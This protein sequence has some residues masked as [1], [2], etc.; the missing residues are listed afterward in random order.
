MRTSA[1]GNQYMGGRFV[2][3]TS[4]TLWLSAITWLSK[5]ARTR[6]GLYSMCTPSLS[7]ALSEAAGTR[8]SI[9]CFSFMAI[10]LIRHA[11]RR[12]PSRSEMLPAILSARP[13]TPTLR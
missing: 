5:N 2:S 6:L 1:V 9:V 11:S 10:S 13:P 3:Y 8:L 12:Q 7:R 4:N